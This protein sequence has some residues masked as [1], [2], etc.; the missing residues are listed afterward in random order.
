VKNQKTIR[1]LKSTYGEEKSNQI[2][3]MTGPINEREEKVVKEI[4]DLGKSN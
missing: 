4:D 2:K 1:H 3:N